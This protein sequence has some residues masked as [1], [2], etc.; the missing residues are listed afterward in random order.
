VCE[1]QVAPAT[2]MEFITLRLT[3]GAEGLLE[4]VE[5]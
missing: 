2:P 5:Q 1:I 3:L 4:V